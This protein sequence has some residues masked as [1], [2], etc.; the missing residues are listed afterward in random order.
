M[1]A[2][3]DAN[4]AYVGD[5]GTG[6]N[7]TQQ[8]YT[9]GPDGVPV[10]N[11][12]TPPAAPS[13]TLAQLAAKYNPLMLR[14]SL[15][16]ASG[17][18]AMGGVLPVV[19]PVSAAVQNLAA[20]PGILYRKYLGDEQSLKEA[21]D[22]E[23]NLPTVEQLM[24]KYGQ[25]IA[26]KN[27]LGQEMVG[28]VSKAMQK[29]KVPDAWPVVPNAPRRPMLTPDDVRVMYGQGK[30]T[31][32]EVRDI[33]TDFQNA[34]SGVK[35]QNVYGEDTLGA[36]LQAAADSVGDTLERRR[37][38]GSSALA[39]IPD[40]L[41]PPSAMYA[42][43]PGGTKITRP[44]VP[45]SA[46]DYR[47]MHSAVNDIITDAFG[48]NVPVPEKQVATLTAEYGKRFLDPSRAST[49]LVRS[50][51]DNFQ[52]KKIQEM[53]PDASSPN[54]AQQ[55]FDTEFM[56]PEAKAKKKSQMLEE[57]M[58]SPESLPIKQ[59]HAALKFLDSAPG[60]KAIQQFNIDQFVQT[61][62]GAEIAAQGKTK[63]AEFLKTSAGKQVLY[64]DSSAEF[65]QTP[66]GQKI[67]E[68]ITLPSFSEFTNRYK[69][70]ERVLKGPLSNFLASDIGAEKSKTVALA[71]EGIVPGTLE[72]VEHLEQF[73]DRPSL[74][75]IRT[76]AGYPAMG[77]YYDDR[78]AALYKRDQL[79]REIE[80]LD[81]QLQPLRQQATEQG[82]LPEQV[83]GYADL[84]K[85]IRKKRAEA[86]KNKQDIDNLKL[87][88]AMEDVTDSAVRA[89]NTE[90]MKQSIPEKEYPFF[91]SVTKAKPEETHYVAIDRVL[92]DLG[93]GDLAKS[94]QED[95]LQGNL[96]DTKN[97]SIEKYMRQKHGERELEK[98]FEQDKAEQYVFQ[99]QNKLKQRL[100][101]DPSVKRIGNAAF[102]ESTKDT[103]KDVALADASAATAV[104]DHCVG[105]G[106]S[107][108]KDEFHPFTGRKRIQYLPIIDPLTGRRSAGVSPGRESA[109]VNGLRHGSELVHV[110][111]PETG[112]PKG[113]LQLEKLSDRGF[114]LGYTSGVGNGAIDPTFVPAIRNYLNTRADEIASAGSNLADKTG[115]YD[116]RDAQGFRSAVRAA[117]LT[118][119]DR[120]A[121]ASMPNLPRFLTAE[122]LKQVYETGAPAVPTEMAVQN[123]APV[124]SMDIDD[125]QGVINQFTEAVDNA[126]QYALE[127]SGLDTPERVERRVY[128][129]TSGISELHLNDAEGFIA[130]PSAR[131]RR[132]ERELENSIDNLRSQTTDFDNEVADGLD[133][134]LIDVRGIR[135][136]VER[137]LRMAE[138]RAAANQVEARLAQAPAVQ[139]DA[140]PQ[141]SADEL[142]QAHG[143]R[144]DRE[145]QQWLERFITNWESNVDDSPGGRVAQRQLAEQYEQWL[146]TNR[147]GPDPLANLF[148][149]ITFEPDNTH[150]ANNVALQQ[151]PGQN[152]DP[153]DLLMARRLLEI[154]REPDGTLRQNGIDSTL[155]A[156]QTGQ[157]DHPLI[158]HIPAGPER[159]AR[160]EPVMR[161]FIDEV[162]SERQ[163][164]P[165]R[166][167]ELYRNY[168][169]NF[170]RDMD[171]GRINEEWSP[172]E[173]A[174]FIRGDDDAGTPNITQAEREALARLVE[175]HGLQDNFDPVARARNEVAVPRQQRVEQPVT[176]RDRD[177]LTTFN[178]LVNEAIAEGS[179]PD[180]LANIDLVQLVR[181]NEIGGLEELGHIDR[182]RLIELLERQQPPVPAGQIAAQNVYEMAGQYDMPPAMI[183]RIIAEESIDRLFE[184]QNEAFTGVGQFETLPQSSRDGAVQ[185]IRDLLNER[186]QQIR[187]ERQQ[188]APQLPAP[189][190]ADT[191]RVPREVQEMTAQD[192][193][194]GLTYGEQR[195]AGDIARQMFNENAF[196]GD[197]P[198]SA[199]TYM[200]RNYA[201]GLAE[202]AEPMMREQAAR[203]LERMYAE[204]QHDAQ[205]VAESLREVFYDDQEGPAQALDLVERDL[206]DLRRR[207]E[208]VWEDILGPMAEDIQ[209][210]P[211]TGALLIENLERIRDEIRQRG[212][213]EG[214]FAKG[215][216]V[217]KPEINLR[218]ISGNPELVNAA[219]KY[220]GYVA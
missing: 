138:E 36:K 70:A 134:L 62:E 33:P 179:F 197:T 180:G 94:L 166:Q 164:S 189:Q 31:A 13:P 10:V 26:P 95:I 175:E 97:L 204:A 6:E 51:L 118:E 171:E 87:A 79:A 143:H 40:V 71:R 167:N 203:N 60:K 170:N 209:W 86:E 208:L 206:N 1:A 190:V 75:R 65:L 132:V 181:E 215:G 18:I 212:D 198:I 88:I 91:P 186:G 172:D 192:L 141:M 92:R 136:N 176:G 59:E 182:T 28:G 161:A 54:A 145:Q 200:L 3:Y 9:T 185:L 111:D 201:E 129:I 124:P 106:G 157:L 78:T 38:A 144:M 169:D 113:T 205:S 199:A 217:K 34:Q 83:E 184:L 220:G 17:A 30:Q 56:N 98:Q 163:V 173:L 104:L 53:Y 211:T 146:A 152:Y 156:L 85:Q 103:P 2:I 41:Q 89:K 194:R 151:A 187:N 142:L 168:V 178:E 96:G 133:E 68:Q 49:A 21:A 174:E 12:G 4:G 64:R 130:E 35:R 125:Y 43:R 99:V 48:E 121:L 183:R 14:K 210:S 42:V 77:T 82:V 72:D 73:A 19:A 102:I 84:N 213:D 110:I 61:P 20:Q 80:D 29:L 159:A 8:Y 16:D 112:L 149:A 158:N 135:A 147:L 105:E 202:G 115:I 116:T 127:N 22:I 24:Q 214:Q 69:E 50:A 120:L 11:Y 150:P 123:E 137:R 90:E 122:D 52:A 162:A 160:L 32:R 55:M 66:A 27:E 67:K 126:A 188:A 63:L 207:G 23:K 57:F 100:D 46:G 219:Y 37:A 216:L 140:M 25:A 218:R 108:G 117:K 5:D 119:A 139:G 45:T 148:D 155:Y 81:T 109:Y 196:G 7:S 74:A 107:P 177:L 154:E 114:T 128:N 93:F 15:Q 101:S 195:R 44:T 193:L 131:L 47:P 165:E 153:R 76:A 58:A 39:G 191:D